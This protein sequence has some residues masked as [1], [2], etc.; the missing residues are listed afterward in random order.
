MST[1]P[2]IVLAGTTRAERLFAAP[3]RAFSEAG[4]RVVRHTDVV[5]FRADEAV[6][7]EAD[8]LLAQAA[9]GCSAA[10]IER[11]PRLRAV[12][13]PVT[14]TEGFDEAAASAM[15]VLVA[16]CQTEEN[17][18]S[19]A[20]S[21][22][23]MILAAAYDLPASQ[24]D[25]VEGRPPPLMSRG[26]LLQGKTIGLVGFGQIAQGVAGRLRAW[27]TRILVSMPRLHS[28]LPEY[29]ER[30]G[31]ETLLRN[32]DVVSLH[33][34]LSDETWH[35]LDARLIGLMKPNVIL[36]NTARGPIVDE[37]ALVAFALANPECRLALDTFEEEPLPRDSGL[38]TLQNAILTPHIVGH[39]IETH[40][41][42][43][44][45]GIA[46]IQGMMAGLAPAEGNVRNPEILPAWRAKWAG[47]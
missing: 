37:A 24:K 2:T 3:T 32:S 7:A 26:R 20:E 39:T 35:L 6:L 40:Q 34:R 30:V 13:S 22:V 21:T 29:V 16:H 10:Q 12:V 42:G 36:V 41:A 8:V 17:Y 25:M 14:G 5:A 4:F 31:L 23:L 44:R 43:R 1:V 18:S 9:F 45:I 11:A 15:G 33:A 28:D 47:M 19:I 27:G 38:R 46:M